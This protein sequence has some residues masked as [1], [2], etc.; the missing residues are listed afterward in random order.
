[1][2]FKRLM[3]LCWQRVDLN[4]LNPSTDS[5]NASN[6]HNSSPVADCN[7]APLW[8]SRSL[9]TLASKGHPRMDHECTNAPL[10]I[11]VFV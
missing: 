3:V 9:F 5:N 6:F 7:I 2:I 10:S 11:R 4:Y 1:M 8:G